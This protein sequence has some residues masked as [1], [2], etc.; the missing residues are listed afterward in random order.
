MNGDPDG[1]DEA[2]VAAVSDTDFAGAAGRQRRSRRAA[3][4]A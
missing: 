4:R 2:I 1:P 3:S